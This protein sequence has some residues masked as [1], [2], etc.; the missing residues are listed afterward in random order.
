MKKI[1]QYSMICLMIVIM[2]TTTGF[3]DPAATESLQVK[4][5]EV[6]VTPRAALQSGEYF[7]TEDGVDGVKVAGNYVATSFRIL[8]EPKDG[9]NGTVEIGA[10]IGNDAA[11]ARSASGDLYIPNTV[12]YEGN[13]YDIVSI[14]KYAFNY[15]QS[16]TSTGLESNTTV[17]TVGNL[18]YA[19]CASLT[20][21]G[22]ESNDKVT[23]IGDYAFRFCNSLTSTGL[24]S[25]D[26]VTT[27]GDYAFDGCDGLTST[28]LESNNTVTAIG[29]AAFA[30]CT[31]L[32]STGLE[33]NKTVT[34]VGESA[35]QQCYK[36]LSTGL[37]NN[38]T[39]TT[40]GDYAFLLCTSM[41]DVILIE[42]DLSRWGANVFN[43]TNVNVYYPKNATNTETFLKTPTDWR[44]IPYEV[45]SI[46]VNTPSK[47]NYEF[48]DSYDP[49]D[50]VITVYTVA[51]DGFEMLND[52]AYNE[53]QS[54]FTFDLSDNL[55]ASDEAVTITYKGKTTTLD[56]NVNKKV[57][58]IPTVNGELEHDGTE[59]HI[60]EVL[61][62]HD[63]STMQLV[64]DVLK[65]DAGIY[66]G[67][68]Q[69]KDVD[70][71][72]WSDGT[73]DAK[74][75]TWTIKEKA[76]EVD[77]PSDI[78]EPTDASKPSDDTISDT[79]SLPETNSSNDEKA[80]EVKP[81]FNGEVANTSTVIPTG[82]LVNV[83]GLLMLFGGSVLVGF[84]ILWRKRNFHK[85]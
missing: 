36:L 23:T 50:L 51:E 54:D 73:S 65:S 21:T 18:A 84:L 34:T 81:V 76:V 15:C 57:I 6:E 83:M 68:V 80:V 70:N 3:T 30:G 27:I 39:V 48:G 31:S 64:G 20:S 11:I 58:N 13:T 32:V 43:M 29:D 71:Y 41:N 55:K 26:M 56:I 59:H 82:D 24:E 8:T 40:I 28:G 17:T 66:T 14:G 49:T 12:T 1:K 60:S 52:I 44:A 46:T 77:Q 69:L 33:K 67:K 53:N 10:G 4:D 75:L 35:F 79:I 16:L 22:L 42:T 37:E 9:Q 2:L 63:D 72:M 47:V 78:N 7:K 62:G 25:N 61:D 85:Q 19:L 45:K 74:D 5:S 38:R